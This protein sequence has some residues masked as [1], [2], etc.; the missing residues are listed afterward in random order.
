MQQLPRKAGGGKHAAEAQA[1]A[2]HD[3]PLL[4]KS[5]R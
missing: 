5:E 1:E 4:T 2:K 3:G